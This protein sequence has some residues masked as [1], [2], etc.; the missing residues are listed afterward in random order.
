M[1]SIGQVCSAGEA[2][3]NDWNI[4]SPD[5]KER[6]A[7]RRPEPEPPAPDVEPT[8]SEPSLPAAPVLR[9]GLSWVVAAVV[10]VAMLAVGL[11]I[12]TFVLGTG[13]TDDAALSEAAAKVAEVQKALADSED[14]NWAYYRENEAL[15]AEL[16]QAHVGSQDAT[17]TTSPAAGE[18]RTYRDGV[19][20]VGEDIAP[21]TYDGV[22]TGDVGYWARLNATDGS[23]HAII[24]N[25]LPRGPF[26]LTV[27]PADKAVELR[28]VRLT[29]R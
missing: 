15:K 17:T 16:E 7:P 28:G 24:A 26:V 19:Y 18:E 20:L 8:G 22:V 11:V 23:T 6:P 2:L 21:G 4:E 5:P 9:G 12:G 10:G 1:S 3:L 25:G 14:R 27:L 29:I 13:R